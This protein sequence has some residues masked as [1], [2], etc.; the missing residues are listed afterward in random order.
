MR[1]RH[2]QGYPA[3]LA[4][5]SFFPLWMVGLRSLYCSFLSHCSDLW[6]IGKG[7]K[8]QTASW[9]GKIQSSFSRK[10]D[11]PLHFSV[12]FLWQSFQSFLEG[13]MSVNSS[14]YIAAPKAL[15]L[16]AF[17]LHLRMF[18]LWF[19]QSPGH[20]FL[21]VA[22]CNAEA[23]EHAQSFMLFALW[24]WIW[25]HRHISANQLLQHLNPRFLFVHSGMNILILS[26][27]TV[28]L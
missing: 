26:V 1:I 12:F 11:H 5:P 27:M 13:R 10:V 16:Y 28:C 8:L 2:L 3:P 15:R 6:L 18:L 25:C 22:T 24:L 17:R 21:G 14:L 23:L 20:G 4:L 9:W 19:C 7:L